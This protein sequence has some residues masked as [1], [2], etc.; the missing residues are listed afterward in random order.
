MLLLKIA[1][2]HSFVLSELLGEARSNLCRSSYLKVSITF[3]ST[4]QLISYKS[5]HIMYRKFKEFQKYP[6]VTVLLPSSHRGQ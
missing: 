6:N 5:T 3:Y 1:F 2:D 4:P